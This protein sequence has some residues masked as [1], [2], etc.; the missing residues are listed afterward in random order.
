MYNKSGSKAVQEGLRAI[1]G[2]PQD[3]LSGLSMSSALELLKRIFAPIKW[4]ID[5]LLPI[6]RHRRIMGQN[7]YIIGHIGLALVIAEL[8]KYEIALPT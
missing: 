8:Q 4:L 3:L 7:R 5:N 6:I 1:Q 2:L